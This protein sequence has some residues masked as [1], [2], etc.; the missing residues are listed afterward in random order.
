MVYG[1]YYT[2]LLYCSIYNIVSIIY[3]MRH[4]YEALD[5]TLKEYKKG[6]ECLVVMG[7]FNGKVGNGREENIIGPYG[8][9]TRNENGERLISFCKKHNLFVTNTWF[10]QKRS[11]QHTWISPGG[12]VK[13]QIDFVLVDSRFRN[14]VK[15]SKAM[16]GAHCETDHKPVIARLKIKL[17]RVRKL[18]QAKKW[19]VN[20]LKNTGVRDTFKDRLNKKIEDGGIEDYD[21]I[22]A[23][24]Q[25]EGKHRVGSG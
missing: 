1:L 10:Q 17:Q 9:G 4:F 6:R 15:N 19:N 22:D 13:N 5:Q 23:M 12:R 24:E 3:I 21:E 18:K 25:V 20:R 16:P 7:N 11:A 8:L 2:I 14:G